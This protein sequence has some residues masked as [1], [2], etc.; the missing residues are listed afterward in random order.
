MLHTTPLYGFKWADVD[1]PLIDLAAATESVA[2]GAEAALAAGGM[3]APGAADLAAVAARVGVLENSRARVIYRAPGPP[4]AVPVAS[5]GTHSAAMAPFVLDEPARVTVAVT[6]R[7]GPNSFNVGVMVASVFIAGI[8]VEPQLVQRVNDQAIS[9]T[10]VIDLAAGTHAVRIDVAAFSGAC[11][12]TRS[13]L[14]LTA[15][16]AE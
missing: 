14:V 6:H 8:F 4:S 3:T 16:R 7:M 12:W 11:T 2:K 13:D 1:T 9:G 10:G 15:G 5:G